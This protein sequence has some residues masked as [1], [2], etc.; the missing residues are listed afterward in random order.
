MMQHAYDEYQQ[1]RA[2]EQE[3]PT[4]AQSMLALSSHLATTFGN[5]KGSGITKD[6][7]AEH[8]GARSVSDAAQVAVQKL[9]NG[10]VLSPAQWDAFHDLISQPRQ[11][12]WRTAVKEGQRKGVAIDFLPSDLQGL[13]TGGAASAPAGNTVDLR[14]FINEK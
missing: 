1:A 5:V 4:G 10:D 11:L 13:A 7:I 12:S 8:L 14:T 2:Q 9:T 3:L 6:M